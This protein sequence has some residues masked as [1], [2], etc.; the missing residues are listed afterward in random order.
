M[1]RLSDEVRRTAWFIAGP[2]ASGKSD[3]ALALVDLLRNK[4]QLPELVAMDSMTLYRGMDIG[5]AK[6]SQRDRDVVPH[7]LFDILEIDET[8]SVA[9]FVSAAEQTT[10]EIV[11]RGGVPIVVGGT[12][13][14]LRS[15]LR[16][17]FEGPPADA[18]IRK[19]LNA[20]WDRLGATA[21]H[22]RLQAV[23]GRT[24]ERIAVNDGRRIIRALEVL[25]A[26]GRPLSDWQRE[27][28]PDTLAS[29][30]FWLEPDRA[31]LHRRINLRVDRMLDAGWLDE[32]RALLDSAKKVGPTARQA[33]GYQELFGVIEN[34][35]D[36]DLATERIKARTR[37]FAK[38]Q[39]TWF[40]NLDECRAVGVQI[41]ESPESAAMRILQ[42]VE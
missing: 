12:G 38:R 16:G 11:G 42:L 28:Q 18:A 30:V 23:D 2:T 20:D 9:D 36:L 31:E 33:L 34:G 1:A 32:A 39:H 19:R 15:L 17:V 7:H 21:M 24:A 5:T 29:R 35:D 10:R 6:P 8:Y 3:V 25:E 27:E 14:Y 37:Q 22:S 26:T 41:G 40:R 4:G 13:L